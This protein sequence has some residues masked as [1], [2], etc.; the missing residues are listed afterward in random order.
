MA[1]VNGLRPQRRNR[2]KGDRTEYEAVRLLRDCGMPAA[3]RV[4]LS[5]QLAYISTAFVGDV[6]TGFTLDGR[7]QKIQ[8]KARQ[9]GWG[10]LHRWLQEG[11]DLLYL[12]TDRKLPIVAMHWPVFATL[13]SYLPA[14]V[15][16][17]KPEDALAD[18]RQAAKLSPYAADC[19]RKLEAMRKENRDEHGDDLPPEPETTEPKDS[20]P[21]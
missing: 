19:L 9:S 4:P 11:V 6:S 5:G 17:P 3:R 2:K 7:E 20:A 16:L 13:L 10:E 15:R 14:D 1:S 8:S 21:F 12:R 18:L